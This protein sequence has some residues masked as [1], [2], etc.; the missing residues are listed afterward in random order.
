MGYWLFVSVLMIGALVVV[1][2]A[3]VAEPPAP[4]RRDLPAPGELTARRFTRRRFGY[5]AT[6]V[7]AALVE[8]DR[9]YA[10]LYRAA[11]PEGVALAAARLAA[12][13]DE[14]RPAPVPA[15]VPEGRVAPP[16]PPGAGGDGAADERGGASAGDVEPP[17][18]AD[19]RRADGTGRRAGDH[20]APDRSGGLTGGRDRDP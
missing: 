15:T 13:G 7:R 3:V 8:L 14:D 6:E 18:H 11:G 1:L 4:R 10:E 19:A 2:A 5:D 12:D 9:A 16:S 20:A 17:T